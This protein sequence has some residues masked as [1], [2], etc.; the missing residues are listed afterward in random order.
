MGVACRVHADRF[1]R[2]FLEQDR[3]VKIF[4]L[5]LG[6]GRWRFMNWSRKI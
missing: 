1:D 3:R 4:Q 5:V 2:S 6:A